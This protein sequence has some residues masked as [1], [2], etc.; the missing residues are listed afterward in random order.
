MQTGSIQLWQPHFKGSCVFLPELH[1]CSL[2]QQK[3]W[4]PLIPLVLHASLN[5]R[6]II[7]E[8]DVASSTTA[9]HCS[10]PSHLSEQGETLCS[11]HMALDGQGSSEEKSRHQ[12][13]DGLI[14]TPQIQI[15]VAEMS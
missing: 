15:L 11:K 2:P 12:A 1:T 5:S 3:I 9:T 7:K 6:Y 10:N 8:M 14:K 13:G 4:K